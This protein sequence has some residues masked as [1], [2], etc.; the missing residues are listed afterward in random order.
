RDVADKPVR[1]ART[2][3]LHCARAQPPERGAAAHRSGVIWMADAVNGSRFGRAFDRARLADAADWLAVAVVIAMP[4]STSVFQILIVLWLAAL[5]PTLDLA[6]A[7]RELQNP[8]GLL[9]VLLWCA[10][11]LGMLWANIPWAERLAGLGGF[12][13]L[14]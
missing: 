11:A 2:A 8:I 9:P 12:N 6:A 10:G 13:K 4:W 1:V 7:R 3:R 14:L 5:L